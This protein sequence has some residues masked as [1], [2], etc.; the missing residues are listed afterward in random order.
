MVKTKNLLGGKMSDI[1]D[2]SLDE[3]GCP[4]AFYQSIKRGDFEKF[5]NLIQEYNI[6]VENLN[7]LRGGNILHYVIY[8]DRFEMVKYLI[9]ECSL[10][11]SFSNQNDWEGSTPLNDVISN[12]NFDIIQFL[13]EKGANVNQITFQ[14][15]WASL[16]YAI[17]CRDS[18]NNTKKY[19]LCDKIVNYLIEHGAIC[20]DELEEE[21]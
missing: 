16:D 17:S 9:E 18:T 20:A 1:Y 11:I 3:N 6:K 8:Y 15:Y 4:K 14:D 7:G 12:S 2:Y 5:K 21:E 13:V 19:E 10:N